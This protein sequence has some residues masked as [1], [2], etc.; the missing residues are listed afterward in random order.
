MENYALFIWG[1]GWLPKKCKQNGRILHQET[2]N[3]D[4]PV[5]TQFRFKEDRNLP[6]GDI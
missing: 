3:H 6:P 5:T 4:S 2:M 1:F